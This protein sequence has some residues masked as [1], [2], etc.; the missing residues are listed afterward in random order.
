M[1]LGLI[2]QQTV[3]SGQTLDKRVIIL[4]DRTASISCTIWDKDIQNINISKSYSFK[5]CAVRKDFQGVNSLTTCPDSIINAIDDIGQV[6]FEK[7]DLQENVKT[8]CILSAN[9]REFHACIQCNKDIGEIN[10]NTT[11][12][13]CPNCEFKQ[14]TSS[15]RKTYKAQIT[16]LVKDIQKK[17][18]IPH[19]ALMQLP[20]VFTTTSADEIEDIL[21]QKDNLKCLSQ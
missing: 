6:V 3:R 20:G 21:L 9:C 1:D 8:I 5:E 17:F 10:I 7:K 19:N 14:K 11:R 18:V 13:K 15:V 16:G 12:I 2:E 4:S